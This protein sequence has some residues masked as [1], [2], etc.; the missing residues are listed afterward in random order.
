MRVSRHQLGLD[1]KSTSEL[2]VKIG[3]VSSR[4]GAR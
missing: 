1:L 4:R 3:G 2:M